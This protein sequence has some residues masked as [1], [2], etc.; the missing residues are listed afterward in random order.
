MAL[1]PLDIPAGVYKNGTELEAAGRWLSS[2]LVRWQGGSLRPVN[3]WEVRQDDSTPTSNDIDISA[4]P[5]RGMH[6]WESLDGTI[7]LA[8]GSYNEIKVALAS[9]VIYNIKPTSGFTDGIEHG[10]FSNGY[11]NQYYGRGTYGDARPSVGVRSEA[12]TVA[13]DNFGQHL[14]FCSSSDGGI[15]RWNLGSSTPAAIVDS[16]APTDNLSILVTEERF[17]FALGANNNP[18]L[19]QWADRESLTD[20]TVSIQNE[21]GFI[22]LSTNGQIMMG[23][24]TRGQALILTDT[25]AHSMR[26]VGPPYVYSTSKVGSSCG[27]IS[28]KA[29]VDTSA[30]AFWMGPKGFFVFNGNTV[31]EL[32]CDVFDHVFSDILVSQQSK[33]WAWDNSQFGEVWWFYQSQE[34]GNTG[35]IDKYVSY[36]YRE[37]YWSIGSLSRTAGIS[38]G[39][40][41]FPILADGTGLLY[42]HEKVG[43]GVVGAFAESGPI[44]IG[45]GDNIMHVTSIIPDEASQGGVSLK[46]KT[47]FYPNSAETTHGPYSTAN[48]TDVR[49]A[50]RQIKMRCDGTDGADFKVGVMRLETVPGGRR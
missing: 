26:Y 17:I 30:G 32:P 46:F 24:R 6:A 39:L 16:S 34:E 44:Q 15:Y 50:G 14:V 29:A 22:E 21:A 5:P 9:G 40:F 28:R 19:V 43:T 2:N 23:L 11:G 10:G 4:N 12:T 3:G 7:Y 45:Q 33:V 18:R 13:F 49:F 47:R 36:S 20:W 8:A 48:P 42:N 41:Q 1:I 35:E 27:V 25:D 38:R 31:T 37:N